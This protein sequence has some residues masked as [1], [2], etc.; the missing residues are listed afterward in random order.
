MAL[1]CTS[2]NSIHVKLINRFEPKFFLFQKVLDK[3]KDIYPFRDLSSFTCD[4][5]RGQSPKPGTYKD[6]R[7]GKY[8]FLRTADVKK[9][10]LNIEGAVYLDNATFETQRSNRVE[11]LDLLISVVGN[12]L[13]STGVIPQNIPVAAFNDNSARIRIKKGENVSPYY[14]SAFLNS[15]FGQRLIQSM[16][17]RT[18]QKILS[19][20]NVKKI[21]IPI[22]NDKEIISLSESAEKLE[23]DANSL[24]ESARDIFYD[25]ILSSI[26]DIE[27]KN[28][29]SVKKSFF[30]PN[31]L[32]SVFYSYPLFVDTATALS[33]NFRVEQL[34][35]LVELKSGNEVGSE[36]YINYVD[37]KET[38]VPFIRTSDIVNFEIDQYPDFYIPNEIYEDLSQ[39]LRP[40]DILF[41]KDGKIGMVGMI[42]SFDKCIISSG[43]VSLRVSDYAIQNSVSPE[44]IFIALSMKEVGIYAARRR[45]VIASTIPHIREERIRQ[46]EIP[47]LSVDVM[48]NITQL[49]SKSFSM[50]SERKKLIYRISSIMDGYFNL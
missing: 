30:V 24:I 9:H 16:V 43:F 48:D 5:A 38:D 12:Y 34:G 50:K 41:T 35:K 3:A 1:K 29:F 23:S 20:G 6:K 32:W 49:V 19:A 39:D 2:I 18:G 21:P 45:T 4:V 10:N 42:T 46:I 28:F 15:T 22:I 8:L 26:N 40:T 33:S 36:E 17:T 14:L 47:I 37:R 11:A 7:A 44:Y 27:K 25:N 13:G 31:D